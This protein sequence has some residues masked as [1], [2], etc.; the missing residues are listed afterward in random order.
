M[1]EESGQV[2]AENAIQRINN[3]TNFITD[4][5]YLLLG[6]NCEQPR[7]DSKVKHLKSY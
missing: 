6:L 2:C 1:V 7:N 4:L 5:L 3:V